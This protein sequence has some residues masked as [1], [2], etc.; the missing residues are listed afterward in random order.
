V[1]EKPAVPAVVTVG[2]T[3]P[4]FLVASL[5]GPGS[6]RLRQWLGRPVLLVFYHPSSPTAPD[7]LRYAQR[8]QATYGERI[9]VL[10]LSVSG[11]VSLVQRQ[12]SAWGL[13][14]P[15]LNGSALRARYAVEAT[16]KIVLLD[17]AGVVRGEHLGWGHETPG[18]VLEELRTCLSQR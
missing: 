1:D 11:D 10:G 2:Y 9:A 16:P 14:F 7:L 4:D 18:A 17:G 5:T 15:V 6:A 13:T 8:L 12:R 3:A